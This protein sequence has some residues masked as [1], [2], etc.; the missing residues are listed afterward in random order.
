[1]L[2]A[3][4]LSS[5]VDWEESRSRHFLSAYMISGFTYVI[6]FNSP[7][8]FGQLQFIASLF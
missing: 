7:S 5:L 4:W 2:L 6:S 3:S 1:M 8:D